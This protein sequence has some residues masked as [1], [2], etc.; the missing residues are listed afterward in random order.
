MV[1]EMKE[2]VFC[3]AIIKQHSMQTCV[4]MILYVKMLVC[5]EF[6]IVHFIWNIISLFFFFLFST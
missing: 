6:F 3:C 1:A 2:T 5:C 4:F